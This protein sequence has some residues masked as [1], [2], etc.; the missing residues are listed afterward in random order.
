ML[1]GK[2]PGE[3]GFGS[4]ERTDSLLAR[5]P[6]TASLKTSSWVARW[7]HVLKASSA[8]SLMGC[9]C[10]W[11]AFLYCCAWAAVAPAGTGEASTASA[12]DLRAKPSFHS[13]AT[14]HSAEPIDADW[15]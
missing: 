14:A 12:R 10:C 3:P 6:R 7:R 2:A 5:Q 9:T 15:L 13:E 8:W 11:T 4:G 1:A